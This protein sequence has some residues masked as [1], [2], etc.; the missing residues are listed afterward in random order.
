MPSMPSIS[1]TR[2]TLA[3]VEA[4]ARA[5]LVSLMRQRLTPLLL[6][7]AAFGVAV[8]LLMSTVDIGVRFRLFEDLLLAAE[9]LL[10]HALALLYGF[11]LLRRDQAD[12]LYILPLSTT[13][14]R[15]RYLVARFLGVVAGVF[16]VTLVMLLLDTALLAAV[17]G[18]VRPAFL[19]Q[20]ALFGMS[21]GLLAA[22]VFALAQVTSPLGAV[23][24]AA[25]FWVAGNGLDEAYLFAGQ[26]LPSFGMLA[27]KVAYLLLP[28]FSLFDLTSMVVNGASV[29]PVRWLFPIAYGAGYAGL[30]VAVAARRF[31]GRVLV[32]GD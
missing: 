24:Y 13:L 29:S 7:F 15:S 25:A 6:G 14:G 12:L 4:L 19:G 18:A 11:D 1:T 9:G 3:Q 28:N 27:V 10:L 23:L 31:R 32:G 22:L 16:A 21:A 8:A 20:V 30:L 2:R 5:T 17:E 26:H